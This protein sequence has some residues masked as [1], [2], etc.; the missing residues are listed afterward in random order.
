[1]YHLKLICLNSPQLWSQTVC[2]DCD[3]L[4][5]HY[6]G[7]GHCGVG[8]MSVNAGMRL[9]PVFAGCVRIERPLAAW[10]PPVYGPC[11]WVRG[12]RAPRHSKHAWD[13]EVHIWRAEDIK[14]RPWPSENKL[15]LK[16]YKLTSKSSRIQHLQGNY[17]VLFG[18]IW[19]SIACIFYV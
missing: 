18:S 9:V 16:K 8:V 1:M 11:F 2:F 19:S 4:T 13:V 17:A 5:G 7:R 10:A 14:T 12:P 15:I 3:G 6:I